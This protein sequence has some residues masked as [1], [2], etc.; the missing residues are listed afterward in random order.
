M[1]LFAA[2]L[3]ILISLT[4]G[5]SQNFLSTNECTTKLKQYLEDYNPDLYQRDVD[6]KYYNNEFAYFSEY[7]I[8]QSEEFDITVTNRF[9]PFPQYKETCRHTRGEIA[10]NIKFRQLEGFDMD[11]QNLDYLVNSFIIPIINKRFESFKMKILFIDIH[12]DD[13]LYSYY[14]RPLSVTT[15]STLLKLKPQK[16]S[17]GSLEQLDIDR[18]IKKYGEPHPFTISGTA[19]FQIVVTES[20]YEDSDGFELKKS[21]LL[22][23]CGSADCIYRMI[24]ENKILENIM[25]IKPYDSYRF[26]YYFDS[27]PKDK[28]V[29][30]AVQGLSNQALKREYEAV[31]GN[32]WQYIKE[33]KMKE[34]LIKLIPTITQFKDN[35]S[36]DIALFIAEYGEANKIRDY[37]Y[38]RQNQTIT[39][40]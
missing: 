31:G 21:G 7:F 6:I 9:G 1:K 5:S 23:K 10:V 17:A 28:P 8:F 39:K 32:I 4:S 37:N 19:I 35:N 15:D 40:K 29:I 30:F 3:F 2:I 25:F 36:I 13:F 24:D 26:F 27:T 38:D 18:Y 34:H 12:F 22:L 14:N 16:K 11:S 33:D 20:Q